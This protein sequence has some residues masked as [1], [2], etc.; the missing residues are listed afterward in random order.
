[1]VGHPE[2]AASLVVTPATSLRC[3][4]DVWRS[5]ASVE[6]NI[7]ARLGCVY[8]SPGIEILILSIV[9]PPARVGRSNGDDRF[10]RM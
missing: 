5:V 3:S 4:P 8:G 2:Q 6:S 1:M 7:H 10:R 9:G